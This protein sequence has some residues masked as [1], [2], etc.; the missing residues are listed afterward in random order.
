MVPP[1]FIRISQ[2]GPH[3]ERVNSDNGTNRIKLLQ[4]NINGSFHQLAGVYAATSGLFTAPKTLLT[5]FLT[6]F[7]WS[8]Q[9]IKIQLGINLQLIINIYAS[10]VNKNPENY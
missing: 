10:K 7:S 3:V 5:L 9:L 8:L 2:Y 1:R 6:V 4:F